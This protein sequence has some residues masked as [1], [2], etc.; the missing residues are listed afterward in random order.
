MLLF[1]REEIGHF[2]E[3]DL[4]HVLE[5]GGWDAIL[6]QSLTDNQLVCL[7]DQFRAILWGEGSRG[8]DG[9]PNAAIAMA[10]LLLAKARDSEFAEGVDFDT[11][12]DMDLLREILMV[13]SV[14]ADR[15]L[16]SR[17]LKRPSDQKDLSVLTGIE[18][19]VMQHDGTSPMTS[20]SATSHPPAGA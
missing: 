7:T 11:E 8:P 9:S 4:A 15:E 20:A 18:A 19:L 14:A 1:D 2:S 12:S 17:L 3:M 6:P 10:M 16:V 5:A 13:L